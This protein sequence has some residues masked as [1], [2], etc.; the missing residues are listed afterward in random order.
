MSRATLQKAERLRGRRTFQLLRQL[1]F[2]H[3]EGP[4]R[5]RALFFH[6]RVE[7][8]PIRVAFSVARRAY[9]KAHDRN[10]LR[11]LL[12]EAYRRQKNEFWAAL[13]KGELWLWWQGE[14]SATPPSLPRLQELMKRLFWQVLHR[15]ATF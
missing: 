7:P 14:A 8:Y 11:R 6:V 1:G 12:R 10:R 13:P 9:R 5:V 4:L 3:Q 2:T 15:C